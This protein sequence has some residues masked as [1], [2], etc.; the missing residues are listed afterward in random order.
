MENSHQP[1]SVI[2]NEGQPASTAG[3]KTTD[4]ARA[5]GPPRTWIL[6]FMSCLLSRRTLRVFE[7]GCQIEPALNVRR[8]AAHCGD[9]GEVRVASGC[10]IHPMGARNTKQWPRC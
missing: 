4:Y 5:F 9:A 10:R 7:T 8:I 3:V 2:E 6:I 1:P